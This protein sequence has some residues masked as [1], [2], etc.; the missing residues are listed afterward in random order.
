MFP[1]EFFCLE[2]V[3][4]F[5][6]KE[7]RLGLKVLAFFKMKNLVIKLGEDVPELI[8]IGFGILVEFKDSFLEY[9]KQIANV[10]VVGLL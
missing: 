9:E 6:D 1:F 10:L 7:G 5:S 2:I 4:D 3:V 8:L